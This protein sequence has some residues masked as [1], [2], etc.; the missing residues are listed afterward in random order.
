MEID[1]GAAATIMSK[2]VF[3]DHYHFSKVPN[4]KQ[5]GEMLSIYTGEKI[6]IYGSADV[7]VSVKG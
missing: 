7:S 3:Y 5:S 1:P 6:P 4:V 2:D